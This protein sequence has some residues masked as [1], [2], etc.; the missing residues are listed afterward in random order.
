MN[1]SLEWCISSSLDWNWNFNILRNLNKRE[2]QEV[3]ALLALLENVS[4]NALVEDKRIWEPSP[5]RIFSLQIL[6]QSVD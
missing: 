2:I 5:S 4:I 1:L 3:S 6:F